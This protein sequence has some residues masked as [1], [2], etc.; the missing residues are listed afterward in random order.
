MNHRHF[1]LNQVKARI[2]GRKALYKQFRAVSKEE[3]KE[4]YGVDWPPTKVV[5]VDDEDNLTPDALKERSVITLSKEEA[6]KVE[7]QFDKPNT[8]LVEK[9]KAK[10]ESEELQNS[11][12]PL[13]GMLD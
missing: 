2:E 8:S 5:V 12:N 7:E 3:L 4:E 13:S 9:I 11:D 10:L 6:Q 1:K